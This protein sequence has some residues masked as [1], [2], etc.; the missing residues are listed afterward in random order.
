MNNIPGALEVP[1]TDALLVKFDAA[2]STPYLFQ[3]RYPPKTGIRYGYIEGHPTKSMTMVKTE[4][5]IY[6]VRRKHLET[7]HEERCLDCGRLPTLH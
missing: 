3:N 2:N 6:C 7:I 5:G 4:L 1:H